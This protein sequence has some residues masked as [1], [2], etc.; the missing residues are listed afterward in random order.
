MGTGVTGGDGGCALNTT[1]SLQQ[2]LRVVVA[3]DRPSCCP[4]GMVRLKLQLRQETQV[5]SSTAGA[6]RPGV[7]PVC[8]PLRCADEQLQREGMAAPRQ[9]PCAWPA[10]T[11]CF[12]GFVGFCASPTCCG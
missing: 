10:P 4:R 11:S 5:C 7:L 3:A 1:P 2:I 6:G 8:A 9:E 12:I